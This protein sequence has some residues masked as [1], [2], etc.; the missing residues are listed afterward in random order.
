[1]MRSLVLLALLG[2]CAGLEA[3]QQQNAAPPWKPTEGFSLRPAPKRALSVLGLPGKTLDLSK[4]AD[5]G[6]TLKVVM[7][8]NPCSV[9]LIEVLPP[10]GFHSNMTI[11]GGLGGTRDASSMPKAQVPAPPCK[12]KP[13]PMRIVSPLK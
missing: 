1:M 5:P 8:A 6:K 7:P 11:F 4:M 10:E 2:S 3:Q 12:D 9:P 13:A